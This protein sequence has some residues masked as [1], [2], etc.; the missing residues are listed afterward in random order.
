M[1]KCLETRFQSQNYLSPVHNMLFLR[2]IL[3]ISPIYARSTKLSLPITSYFIV[4]NIPTSNTFIF[5]DPLRFV[6]PTSDVI[7]IS[8]SWNSMQNRYPRA[9]SQVTCHVITVLDILT[10]II[11]HICHI[12]RPHTEILSRKLKSSSLR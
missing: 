12:T 3:I 11:S 1:L 8:L 9:K 10:L 7:S 2:Y 4:K 5:F 6:K